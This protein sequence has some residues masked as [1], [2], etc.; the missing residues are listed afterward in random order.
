MRRS[1]LLAGS[2]M[3]LASHPVAAEI[4]QHRPP[5]S[6]GAS[7]AATL[8]APAPEHAQTT[9]PRTL[10]AMRESVHAGLVGFIS[11]GLDGSDLAEAT[12][13]AGSLDG[14]RDLRFLPIAGMGAFQNVTD[15]VFARGIDIGI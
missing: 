4:T 5:G 13:L 10:R 15:I 12:E 1:I 3:F 8:P 7:D 6:E 11:V 2:L 9:A 14:I